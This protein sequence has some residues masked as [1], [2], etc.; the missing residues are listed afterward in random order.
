MKCSFC[1]QD[2]PEGTRYCP[3]TGKRIKMIEPAPAPGKPAARPVKKTIFDLSSPGTMILLVMVIS[4][5][6]LMAWTL[7]RQGKLPAQPLPTQDIAATLAASVNMTSTALVPAASAT[8][9]I[10]LTVAPPTPTFTVAPPAEI[11]LPTRTPMAGAYSACPNAY[12]SILKVGDTAMVSLDPPIEN[13]LREKPSTEALITGK[14]EPGEKV[15]I[16]SGPA[17]MGAYVWWSVVSQSSTRA[18]WT[19][20]GDWNNYWLVKVIE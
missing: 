11:I 15:N 9:T 8:P 3:Q 2:H 7:T 17:C 4:L 6:I 12:P 14:L 20:E 16:V 19:A 10:T 18:G 5:V 13:N 1:G